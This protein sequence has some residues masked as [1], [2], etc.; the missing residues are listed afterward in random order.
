M[1][2]WAVGTE[3]PA[4]PGFQNVD[5]LSATSGLEL[6]GVSR[7]FWFVPED[8]Q[9]RRGGDLLLFDRGRMRLNTEYN[10]DGMRGQASSADTV[11]AEFFT[12]HY[13]GIAEKYPVY[14][15]LFEYAKLVS[16]ARYLKDQG[17]PLHWFLMCTRIWC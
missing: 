11:F 17:V 10:A 2:K 15:E 6:L 7:R 1:K 13:D 16:L 12:K 9:F 5:R 3:R 8:L 4:Y 14:Q